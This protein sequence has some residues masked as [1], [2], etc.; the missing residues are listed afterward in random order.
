MGVGVRG[1]YVLHDT[2]PKVIEIC[3][4]HLVLVIQNGVDGE[5]DS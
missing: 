1:S 5:I 2:I 4:G 3:L